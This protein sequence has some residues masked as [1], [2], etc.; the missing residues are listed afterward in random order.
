MIDTKT[1]ELM[2]I[3]ASVTAHCLA[4]VEYHVNR[5]KEFGANDDEIRLAFAIGRSV[6]QGAAQTMDDFI[7]TLTNGIRTKPFPKDAIEAL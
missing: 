7:P 4:C 6:E 3:S 5:A 2:S 1:K